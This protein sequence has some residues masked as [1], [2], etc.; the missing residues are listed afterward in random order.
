MYLTDANKKGK[1]THNF[2]VMCRRTLILKTCI[3]MPGEVNYN[4]CDL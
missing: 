3:N 4:C 2:T 1:K